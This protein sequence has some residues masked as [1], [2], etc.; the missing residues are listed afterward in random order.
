MKIKMC[1]FIPKTLGKPFKAIALPKNLINQK[2]FDKQAGRIVGFWLP[3]PYPAT[4]FCET[5]NREFGDLNGTNR[6]C[7]Y[8]NLNIDLSKTGQFQTK[9]G[10]M[11]NLF[12]KKCDPSG[13]AFV[14]FA[15][16]SLNV[17]EMEKTPKIPYQGGG[18]KFAWIDRR[19]KYGYL[20]PPQFLRA[21]PVQYQDLVKDINENQ[22][23][24]KVKSSAGYPFLE[25]FSPNIDFE[26]EISIFRLSDCYRIEIN[27]AHNKFP[28]YEMYIN[29]QPVYTFKSTD[30]APN[31]INLTSSTSFK[32]VKRFFK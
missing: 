1:A 11:A 22:S 31:P 3:E 26:F 27:G 12:Q 29:N 4:V 18:G 10:Y 17:R 7:A 6:L 23:V 16:R 5:D 14:Q 32:I 30:T 20:Q 15:Y 8:N 13:R 9:Y 19:R 25:P 2:A 24:I 28:C 21:E